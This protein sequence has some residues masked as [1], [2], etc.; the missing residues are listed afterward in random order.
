MFVWV[1][2]KYSEKFLKIFGHRF[3]TLL[4]SNSIESITSKI[5]SPVINHDYKTVS[6]FTTKKGYGLASTRRSPH[7]ARLVILSTPC[8]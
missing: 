6:N 7:P 3:N 8:C 2:K 5:C 4:Y 1:L